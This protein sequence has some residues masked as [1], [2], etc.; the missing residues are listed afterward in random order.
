MDVLVA[1]GD[2]QNVAKFMVMDGLDQITEIQELTREIIVLYANNSRKNMP[3][4]DFV[5]TRFILDLKRVAFKMTH[6]THCVSRAI[7]IAD[8]DRT[9]CRS[10]NDQIDLEQG[11]KNEPL[12]D[13]YPTQAH[14]TNYT[15]WMEMLQNFLRMICDA[16][17]IPLAAVIRKRLIPLPDSEDIAFGLQHS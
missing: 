15:K 3:P 1:I 11:W 4:S 6:I 7:I 5:S 10:M 12:K 9:W 2:E 17:G 8:I 16:N 13:L 14:I